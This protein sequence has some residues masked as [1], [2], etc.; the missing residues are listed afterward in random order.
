MAVKAYIFSVKPATLIT[1]FPSM[2]PTRQRIW[3]IVVMGKVGQ[4]ARKCTFVFTTAEV[5]DS[6]KHE[7]IGVKKYN[8]KHKKGPTFP[9]SDF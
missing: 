5:Y 2:P 4:K 1:S 6:S 3:M 9:Q 8:K 7:W